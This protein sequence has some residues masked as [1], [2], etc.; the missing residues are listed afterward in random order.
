METSRLRMNAQTRKK[1]PGT[2]NALDA[3]LGGLR[4][5]GDAMRTTGRRRCLYLDGML[6]DRWN[7]DAR[8][9][10]NTRACISAERAFVTSRVDLL[11]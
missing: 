7:Y 10:M 2:Q 1:R 6:L 3:I 9:E 8:K 11:T 4:V 5:R